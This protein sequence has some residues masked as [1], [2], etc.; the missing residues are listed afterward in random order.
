MTCLLINSTANDTDKQLL[1]YS[2]CLDAQADN[3]SCVATYYHS[4]TEHHNH[5]YVDKCFLSAEA[6]RLV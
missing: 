4:C 5:I 6:T 2:A 3:G 1:P